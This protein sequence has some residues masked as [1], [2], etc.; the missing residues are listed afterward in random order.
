MKRI[1]EDIKKEEFGKLYLLYGDEAYLRRLYLKNLLKAL[2]AEDGDM[3]FTRFTGRNLNDDDVLNIGNTLPFFSERRVV[4]IDSMGIFREKHEKLEEYLKEL[5]DYLTI[6]M[7]EEE[8]DKRGKLYKAVQKYGYA[9]EFKTLEEK[10]LEDWVVR[11]LARSG[12]KIRKSTCTELLACT[13]KDLNYISNELEKLIAYSGSRSEITADDIGA[14]CSP[15]IENKIFDLVTAVASGDRK[16]ALKKYDD[17]LILK[18]PPMRILYLLARQFDQL[19][20]I[21]E[22][23]GSGSGYAAI[24]DSLKMNPYVVK[25]SFPLT[26][27]YTTEQ[28]RAAV[29]DMVRAEEDVKTGRLDER[30]SVELMIMKYSG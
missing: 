5:P 1:A 19:L 23:S 10:D 9:A 28:L 3:N 18:E 2:H 4:L 22:L 30:L 6:V 16:T 11:I 21:K 26:R 29:E 13:G 12:K 25:K 15:V 24:A 8:V 14:V 17:L 7:N 20:H 27:R